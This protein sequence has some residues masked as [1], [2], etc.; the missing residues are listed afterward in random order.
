MLNKH[1]GY[2]AH[3]DDVENGEDHLLENSFNQ[4][5]VLVA[6]GVKGTFKKVAK[7]Q[8]SELPF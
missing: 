8:I 6:E 2:R 5:A 7:P 3:I 4:V 1:A